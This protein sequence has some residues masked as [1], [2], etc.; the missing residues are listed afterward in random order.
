[1]AD[2]TQTRIT[3]TEFMALP[4]SNLPI[5]LINGEVIMSPTPTDEHQV[6]AGE[7]YSIL[8]SLIPH[9]KLRIAPLTVYLDNANA[10]Q[11]DLFWVSAENSTCQLRGDYWHGAPDLVV[12]ILSPSTAR[13][14]RTTKFELYEQVRVREYWLIEPATQSLEIWVLDGDEFQWHGVF[15]SA[16]RPT[17]PVLGGQTIDLQAIFDD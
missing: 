13:C 8:K 1:M 10:V 2:Q 9:G 3:A 7:L 4:E 12:E 16:T 14:D 5:E 15:R 6:I 11:P 17:S